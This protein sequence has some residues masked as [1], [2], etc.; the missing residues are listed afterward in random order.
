MLVNMGVDFSETF[1]LQFHT[2]KGKKK[3]EVHIIMEKTMLRRVMVGLTIVVIV[4][5]IANIIRANSSIS[6]GSSIFKSSVI[7]TKVSE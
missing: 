1:I 6:E 5:G 4:L 7:A 2:Y 3:W